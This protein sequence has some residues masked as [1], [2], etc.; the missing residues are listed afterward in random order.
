MTRP[1]ILAC[2]WLAA[3]GERA[4][5]IQNRTGPARAG[6]DVAVTAAAA[7]V[8]IGEAG[9]AFRACQAAGTP[10]NV[11]ATGSLAVRAAPFDSAARSGSIADGARFFVC[12]RSIDQRWLGTVYDDAGTLSPACGV[13]APVARRADY[14]GPCRSG[15][16]ASASV[17]FIAG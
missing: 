10:R 9:P 1:V 11:D 13:S 5:P 4:E 3:C 7:P 8:R 12:S 15:W 6:P 2:L 16:V 14:D 17:R